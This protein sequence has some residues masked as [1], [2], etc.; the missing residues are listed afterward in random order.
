MV[1]YEFSQ[2]AAKVLSALGKKK[3]RGKIKE[4]DMG[5]ATIR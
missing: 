2:I 1:K 5:Q 3:R 4:M